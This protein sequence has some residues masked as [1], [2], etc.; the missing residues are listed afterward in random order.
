MEKEHDGKENTVQGRK[1]WEKG[2]T[3]SNYDLVTAYISLRSGKGDIYIYKKLFKN[4]T[5]CFVSQNY[6]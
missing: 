1:C 2:M 6:T 5:L 3:S 4:P